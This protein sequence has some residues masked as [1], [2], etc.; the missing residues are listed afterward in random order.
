MQMSEGTPA[1]KF[2]EGLAFSMVR[3]QIEHDKAIEYQQR[4]T[5][6]E[7]RWRK[8]MERGRQLENRLQGLELQ[9]KVHAMNEADLARAV[10]TGQVPDEMRRSVVD[11]IKAEEAARVAREAAAA[12]KARPDLSAVALPEADEAPPE[13]ESPA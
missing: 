10:V 3:G 4:Q 12:S 11:L 1:S 6:G 13:P 8:G 2:A 9:A 7:E 5:E